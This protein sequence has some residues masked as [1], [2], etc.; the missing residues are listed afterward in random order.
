MPGTTMIRYTRE[1]RPFTPK[2]KALVRDL[3]L[4]YAVALRLSHVPNSYRTIDHT[5]Y[6]NEVRNTVN[7]LVET[8]KLDPNDWIL[9]P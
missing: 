9:K 5:R 6:F 4:W 3:E 1:I 7:K 8:L 2:Y